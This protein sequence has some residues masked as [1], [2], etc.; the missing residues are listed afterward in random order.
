[1]KI[2]LTKDD[3][4]HILADH[5]SCDY[6]KIENSN[7]ITEDSERGTGKTIVLKYDKIFWEGNPAN[8]KLIN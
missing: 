1:M 8:K 4:L 2:Y 5:F 6:V 7:Y 3:V